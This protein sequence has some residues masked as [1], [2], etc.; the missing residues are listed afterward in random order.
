MHMV[1]ETNAYLAAAKD[2]GMGAGEMTAVVNA[3]AAN[4]ETGDIMPGCG[5]ARKVRVAKPG[6]GKSG[7]YRVITYFAGASRPVFLL[8]VFGEERKGQPDLSRAERTSRPD[9]AS[10][11]SP[12]LAVRAAGRARSASGPVGTNEGTNMKSAFDKIAAGLEDAIAF[13]GGDDA[14]GRK[15]TID[16]KAIRTATKKTQ[17]DFA[18]AYRLPIG[19]VRDWEQGRRQPD[20]G[21]VV[22]LKM[23]EAEPQTVEQIIARVG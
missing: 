17:G 23:I 10:D 7:N 2:A 12:D 16:V 6:T 9:Q 8:T 22:L 18:K 21:S 15:A 14:R 1:I 13:A 4:P 11:G 20:S 3:I 5:G 19:T